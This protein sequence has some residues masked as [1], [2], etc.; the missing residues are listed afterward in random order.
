[1]HCSS[2]HSP[3]YSFL[4]YSNSISTINQYSTSTLV[5]S[6]LSTELTL[7]NRNLI[8]FFWLVHL[9]ARF[10]QFLFVI[11]FVI[12]IFTVDPICMGG[13]IE[14][15][16]HLKSIV[17]TNSSKN[18]YVLHLWTHP[19]NRLYVNASIWINIWHCICKAYSHT[20]TYKTVTTRPYIGA[21]LTF[22]PKLVWIAYIHTS[23]G[24]NVKFAPI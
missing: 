17:I 11:F 14:K 9:I 6:L 12:F 13:K 16:I 21:N 18:K 3:S 22:L 2:F 8:Y 5:Y 4:F 15:C 7:M 24:K 20:H 23:F 1:M 10:D 19:Y